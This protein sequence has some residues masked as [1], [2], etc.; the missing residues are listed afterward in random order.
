MKGTTE[1]CPNAM[2]ELRVDEVVDYQ[3]HEEAKVNGKFFIKEARA[4]A[5]ADALGAASIEAGKRPIVGRFPARSI[6]ARLGKKGEPPS[7]KRRLSTGENV[8]ERARYVRK[9]PKTTP[10]TIRSE[11]TRANPK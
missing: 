4:A 6:W 9:R 5:R 3:V 11:I 8:K 2:K 1:A 7:I 10:P